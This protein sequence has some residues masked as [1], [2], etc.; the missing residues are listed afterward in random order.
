MPEWLA[1][2]DRH[3]AITCGEKVLDWALA[4][5]S[6]EFGRKPVSHVQG[7][8]GRVRGGP[9]GKRGKL[10]LGAFRII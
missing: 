6:T 10:G 2:R 4:G 8:T 9:M 5:C 7:D 1:S 3:R